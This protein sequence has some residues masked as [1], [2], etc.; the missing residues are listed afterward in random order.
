MKEVDR[1]G[2]LA[3]RHF[4]E[5]E[6]VM[7]KKRVLALFLMLLTLFGTMPLIAGAKDGK[8]G[9]AK[10]Y[11]GKPQ[12]LGGSPVKTYITFDN[13]RIPVALGVEIPAKAFANLPA[14]VSVLNLEF[15]SEARVTPFQYLGFDWNPQG[16]E[17]AGLYTKPHFDFH[18]Y[19][20]TPEETRAIKPGPCQGVD[21][22]DLKRAMKDVPARYMPAGYK[23][24][25]AV[26]PMMGNHLIDPASGEFNHQPFTRTFIYGSY[27][28][29]ITFYE[30]MLTLQYMQSQPNEYVDFKLPT[31]Y[32]QSGYYPTRYAV[33]YDADNGVYR[34]S[35]ERFVY[36]AAR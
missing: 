21:C 12:T 33:R 8:D 24:V 16:H 29:K 9:A 36:Q 14:A 2:G 15:P 25:G 30:P 6:G 10:T 4:A 13:N 17:P 32:A 22:A 34:I 28:G 1:R 3:L 27:D 7:S 20:Q 5:G 18:F 11:Y 35:L 31:A 26:A 23:N 19:L